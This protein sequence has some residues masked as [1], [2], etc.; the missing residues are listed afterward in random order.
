MSS[1]VLGSRK[2]VGQPLGVHRLAIG[3]ACD[4]PSWRWVGGDTSRELAKYFDVALFDSFK[5]IPPCDAVLIVK[6]RPPLQVAKALH[7]R[8]VKVIFAPIDLYMGHAEIHRDRALLERCDLVLSHS[9]P[10]LKSLRPYCA[11][12]ALV[13]HHGKYTLPALASYKQDG[14]VLWIGGLQY[15]PYLLDWLARHPLQREVKILTDLGNWEAHCAA[16]SLARRLG[17]RLD[18]GPHS[19]NGHEARMWS[20]TEQLRMM[21]ECKAAIDIKGEDFNQL[22]KPPTKA[23]KFVSSG[24]AFACNS[25]T[26]ASQYFRERGFELACPLEQDRW[27]S[28]GYWQQ[29]HR[30]AS[31]LRE[32]ISIE[33]VGR[34]YRTELQSLWSAGSH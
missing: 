10:L 16:R 5:R 6:H 31:D 14:Y 3:P 2:S 8:G 19:I 23:Q 18:I 29:T 32:R 9:E 22:T 1:Q 4:F 17:L 21:Q 20:K 28:W 11:R 15:A 13:E 25:E 7:D 24:I 12:I 27:F 34:C 30:F 33:F 26:S